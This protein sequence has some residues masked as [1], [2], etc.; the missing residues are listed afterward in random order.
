[1]HL[2]KQQDILWC[3]I[4]TSS[5]STCAQTCW[6]YRDGPAAKLIHSITFYTLAADLICWDSD[7]N[8][9][10]LPEGRAQSQYQGLRTNWTGWNNEMLLAAQMTGG[11]AV[12]Q[13]HLSYTFR[14]ILLAFQ[15]FSTYPLSPIIVYRTDEECHPLIRMNRYITTGK[16]A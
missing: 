5:G 4:W 9:V 1:M 16:E 15:C 3:N 10:T 6:I 2:T 11:N 8:T 13:Q 7:T 14:V 12:A